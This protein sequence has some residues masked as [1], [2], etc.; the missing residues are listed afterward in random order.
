MSNPQAILLPKEIQAFEAPPCFS[1]SERERHFSL[2]TEART[3]FKTLRNDTSR[4]NFVLQWGYFR[5]RGRFFD[6]GSFRKQDVLYVIQTHYLRTLRGGKPPQLGSGATDSRHR[7]EILKLERWREM[8]DADWQLLEAHAHWQA[9]KRNGASELFLALTQFCWTKR[10]VIPSYAVLSRLVRRCSQSVEEKW[11]GLIADQLQPEQRKAILAL[12][13]QTGRN[14]SLLVE[15]KSVDQAIRTRNL[16]HNAKQLA[17]IKSLFMENLAVLEALD[18]NDQALSYYANWIV[19]ATTHQVSQLRNPVKKCLYLLAFIKSQF[20]HR[21]DYA[22]DGVL[23]AFKTVWNAAKKQANEEALAERSRHAPA[24]KAVVASQN[25]MTKVVVDAVRILEDPQ[26]TDKE[27]IELARNRLLGGL[28]DQDDEF[29]GKVDLVSQYLDKEQANVRFYDLLE[30]KALPL[31]RKLNSTLKILVFDDTNVKPRLWQAIEALQQNKTLPTGFL[32]K[33]ERAMVQKDDGTVRANLNKLLLFKH[34]VE[35]LRGGDLNLLYSFTHRSLQ[36][37]EIP[38][39]KWEKDKAEIL[40]TAGLTQ[41]QDGVQHLK[42]L[43]EGLDATYVR[44]NDRFSAGE[45]GYLKMN[46]NGRFRVITPP[47]ESSTQ[48]FVGE[49][50]AQAEEVVSIQ[51]ILDEIEQCYPFVHLLTHHSKRNVALQANPHTAFAGIMAL[52]CNIGPRRM[53]RLSRGIKETALVDMVTWRL[54]NDNLRKVNQHLVKA[55]GELPLGE[56]YKVEENKLYS[57]SDGKKVTVAVDSL[58]ANYSFKYYGKDRG[59]AVYS[60]VDEKQRL[61]H[62]T[63]F[64]ASDREAAYVLDGLLHNVTDINRIHATDTH[65]YTEVLFGATHFMDITFAPRIKQPG[66]QT[67]YCMRPKKYYQQQGYRILPSRP[68]N[69][70]L[71]LDQ[72]DG[73]LRFMATIRL[74]HSSASQ[75]FKRLN[76][77]S[78]GHALYKALKEFGRIIKSQYLLTFFDVLTLR[79]RAQRQ[80]NI[81]ELSN[82]F[83]DAV[84]WARG[85]QFHVGTKEEQEKYTLCRSLLQNTVILWNYLTL[86]KELLALNADPEAQAGMLKAIRGGSVLT[87]R[88]VNF[89]GEYDFTK[90][91]KG[92]SPFP[93]ARIK[94]LKLPP[95]GEDRP[96]RGGKD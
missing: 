81:V 61:F 57:S 76:S 44:V 86:S 45:N 1:R 14:R 33:P 8:T 82:K 5:A 83:H 84:F 74:G 68:I 49:L 70:T 55:I 9:E 64:S 93:L 58:L 19:K 2:T 66:H 60:F 63:V 80:L 89:N 69:R 18:W 54:S 43:A 50:L 92:R 25:E 27:K 20:Y 34:M 71:I 24:L 62:S 31:I 95:L 11:L 15:A 26:L 77:Y 78:R 65:G 10:W 94:A 47:Q 59:V 35:A 52:G 67:L 30:Q 85:K 28:G 32:T 56:V 40:A 37:Y 87:W 41:Y 7:K 22:V 4:L 39:A 96:G 12:L 3:F 88:H 79:Q 75:L 6:P 36:S 13:H 21:Q 51:Q 46:P 72:W 91:P 73:I 53:A 23:K 48:Q 16:Q 38:E 42:K 29:A 17:A 90:S